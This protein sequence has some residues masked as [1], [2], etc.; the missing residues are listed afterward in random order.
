M[1]KE[2]QS[3]LEILLVGTGVGRGPFS[4]AYGL[5]PLLCHGF[6]GALASE[7]ALQPPKMEA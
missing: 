2:K 1:I 3:S 5:S 6:F 4:L 7:S